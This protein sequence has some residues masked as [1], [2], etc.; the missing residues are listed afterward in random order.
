MKAAS[1]E[2]QFDARRP[3]RTLAKLYW[4]ERRWVAL[5]LL[6]YLFKAS[7][8][9]ILPV[10]TANIIDVIARHP[11][12]GLRALWINAAIGAVS[13]AQNI[14]SAA[15]YV[16]CLSR[17]VRNVEIS[18]RS[19]LVRRLQMLS[20]NYHNRVDA[21][22]LQT[23]LTRD[24]ES[25]EMMSRQVVDV[26]FFA[27][28]TILVA[29]AVTAWRMPVFVPVFF[30]F[31]PLIWL[32]RHLLADRLR[33]HNE[34]LRREI[35]GMNSLVL[36]MI[37]L[38]PITRA[39]A[40][41]DE[42]IARVENQFGHVRQAARSFDFVAG[43]FGAAAWVILMLFNL[44][45]LV[46]AALLSYN[47]VLPLTAGDIV[48][49]AGYFNTIMAAMMQLNAM[50][51]IITRGFDGLKSVGEVLESPDLEE[52]RGKRAV[53]SVR[54]EFVFENVGFEYAGNSE[55]PPALRGISFTVAAGETFGIVG[56]SGS[57]KSTL[58]CLII[59]FHRPTTGRILLDGADMNTLDLR[60]FRRHLAVVSQQT[61]LFNGTLRENIIYGLNNASPAALQRA[62]EE[63]NA[64]EFIRELP[65]GLATEL[66]PGGVQLSGGQR[67]RIAIARALLRD[68]R[69]LILDEATSALDTGSEAVVQQALE[70]LMVGRTT[71]IIAHR[72]AVLRK[73]TRILTLDKGVLATDKTN[74]LGGIKANE[75]GHT[76]ENQRIY[77]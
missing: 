21:G 24:V 10:V 28:V 55:A 15:A 71:F 68:P 29:L 59:G 64:A 43:T 5:A 14:P 23:K 25:I 58:A 39:H 77:S 36:S 37:N 38:I 46:A 66:G 22:A 47:G 19:A 7:P 11:A 76:N 35:E 40:V 45:G 48:L 27:L 32:V 72:H 52:N 54:G 67:Q 51:P 65:R 18:L 2:I 70:R 26:G 6:S 74:E 61:I 8:V 63:A 31:L 30:L 60:T 17:S 53:A 73:A 44:A 50:L 34:S 16:T 56:P 49:L 57:G 20:I 41:E 1:A 33:R 42:E 4:P 13:I 3:W 9:W 75:W 69:V 62:I 12:G